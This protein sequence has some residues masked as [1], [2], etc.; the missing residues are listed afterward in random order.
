MVLERKVANFVEIYGRKRP[1]A[2]IPKVT[3]AFGPP[4]VN[5]KAAANLA[6]EAVYPK[7]RRITPIRWR[8]TGRWS[9]PW[10]SRSRGGRSAGSL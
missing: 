9:S 2:D 7:G 1:V 4:V 5:G 10:A 6:A 8:R 3:V